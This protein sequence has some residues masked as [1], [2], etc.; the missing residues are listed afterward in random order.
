MKSRGSKTVLF[1]LRKYKNPT[2]VD[3]AATLFL[4]WPCLSGEQ[5]GL[6]DKCLSCATG[7]SVD[8]VNMTLRYTDPC[9]YRS[10]TH[11]VCVW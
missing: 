4:S 5:P 11:A 10:L 7:S 6:S 9:G 3:S 2:L 1:A 8:R